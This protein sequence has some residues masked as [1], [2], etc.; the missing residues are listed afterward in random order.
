MRPEDVQPRE[1]TEVGA[2][3]KLEPCPGGLARD[4]R[5]TP[6]GNALPPE[7]HAGDRGRHRKVE[8]RKDPETRFRRREWLV[9]TR[10][11]DHRMGA[12]RLLALPREWIERQQS[13]RGV[14][15]SSRPRKP[16]VLKE[17]AAS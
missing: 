11:S 1:S 7:R 15:V 8:P 3:P 13:L 14:D 17:R 16:S 9:P 5:E 2:V 6:R 4:Q 12:R 10:C